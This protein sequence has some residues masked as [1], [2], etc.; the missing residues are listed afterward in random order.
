TAKVIDRAGNTSALGSFSNTVIVSNTALLSYETLASRTLPDGQT[1]V[2]VN[3]ANGDTIVSHTDLEISGRGPDLSLT[4][5]Y[6]AL[7]GLNVLFGQGW[8]SELDEHL[9]INGDGSVTYLE[10]DGGLHVFL[11][12]GSGGY[13]TSPGLFVTLVHNG[14]GT[15]TLT[16]A[17]QSKA[18]FNS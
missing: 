18:N 2:S 1:D 8:T 13:L 17:D 3:V 6:H 11:P 16:S 9:T 15:Y 12:N 10:A 7:G 14:D 5:T 4:R